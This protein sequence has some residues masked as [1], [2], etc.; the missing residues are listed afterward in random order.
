MLKISHKDLLTA[1][2]N[3]LID[4]SIMELESMRP[5]ESSSP[6]EHRSDTAKEDGAAPSSPT[7]IPEP[8]EEHVTELTGEQS[9]GGVAQRKR[10]EQE[11]VSPKYT[12]TCEVCK[13]D[14]GSS[15]SNA[16]Y[17]ST[18]CRK[19]VYEEY[20]ESKLDERARNVENA[21]IEHEC[22]WCGKKTAKLY[23]SDTCRKAIEQAVADSLSVD[24]KEPLKTSTEKHT[25]YMRNYRAKEASQANKEIVELKS[26]S[27]LTPSLPADYNWTEESIKSQR[28]IMSRPQ[29]GNTKHS[30][31]VVRSRD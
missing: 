5:V 12:K 2:I 1:Q 18:E 24:P 15:M 22:S 10:R 25:E 4:A 6:E 20:K 11:K 19:V 13:D 26:T 21:S 16:K 9:A 29:R 30:P 8:S 31:F 3:A 28:R 27:N 7:K 14:F 23:C 17:C